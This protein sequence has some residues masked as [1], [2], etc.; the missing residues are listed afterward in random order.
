MAL[1]SWKSRQTTTRE[2]DA[3]KD[4]AAQLAEAEISIDEVTDGDQL[5]RL[6]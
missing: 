6:S 2:R 5:L 4:H 1:E 3:A